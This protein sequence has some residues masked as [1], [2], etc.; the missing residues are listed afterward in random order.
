MAKIEIRKSILDDVPHGVELFREF[1]KEIEENFG[2]FHQPTIIRKMVYYIT[3][4]ICF[5]LLKDGQR[6]GFIAGII[7]TM[8]FDDRCP[9]WVEVAWF[10]KK[11]HRR[12]GVQLLNKSEEW[13]RANGIKKML[14]GHTSMADEDKMAVFYNKK[15][16][17]LYEKHFLKDL[18]GAI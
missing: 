6:I 7:T 2:E 3:E 15:G 12:Y 13:C 1:H 18:Q 5:T 16:F 10:V 11:E 14:I 9:V 4:E 17:K 8:T